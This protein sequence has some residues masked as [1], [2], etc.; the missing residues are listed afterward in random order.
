MSLAG[1]KVFRRSPQYL[2]KEYNLSDFS[3]KLIQLDQ[4]RRDQKKKEKK[5]AKKI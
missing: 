1:H 2:Y 3:V 4:A 5:A